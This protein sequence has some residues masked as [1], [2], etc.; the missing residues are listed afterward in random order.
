MANFNP[1]SRY[2]NKVLEKNRN[3]EQFIVLKEP[4]ALEPGSGDQ[5]VTINQELLARPDLISYYAYENSQYWWIILEFNG[6]RDPLFDLK[7]GQVLRI[8]PIGAVK[9]ALSKV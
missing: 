5:F 3:G 6:I 8:P 7:I 1:L 4:L 2:K 9:A